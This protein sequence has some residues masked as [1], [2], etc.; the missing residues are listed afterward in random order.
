MKRESW[1]FIFESMFENFDLHLDVGDVFQ[2]AEFSLEKG[3]EYFEHEQLCDEITYVVS[4][5][6]QVS[7]DGECQPLSPGQIHFIRKG[8]AHRIAATP[9]SNF[10]CICIAF[11]PNRENA[12][13]ATFLEAV[14]ERTHFIIDDNGYVKRLG[15]LTVREFYNRDKYSDDMVNKLIAQILVAMSRILSNSAEISYS[16]KGE[17]NSSHS[18]Y[19]VLRYIDREYLQIDS[20]KEVSS[21][22]SYS[23]YYL[24]H[25]FKEK[26]G[27]TMKEYINRKKIA[28]AMELLEQCDLT[29]E[30]ISDHLKYTSPRVFRRVFKQYTGSTPSSYRDK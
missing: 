13:V 4:G 7:S 14:G 30:Q 18:M 19:E 17:K 6:G 1:L 2:V 5:Y 15:E 3:N 24:S 8:C 28:H 16:R 26:M 23:E 11:I 22:L 27:I 25:L 10:R 21:V 9:E 20:V 29:V 12:D